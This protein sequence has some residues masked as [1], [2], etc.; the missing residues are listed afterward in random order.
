MTPHIGGLH[1]GT[2]IRSNA[3][4][5]RRDEVHEARGTAR[6]HMPDNAF[7]GPGPASVIPGS[8][9]RPC[10]PSTDLN[11]AQRAPGPEWPTVGWQLARRPTPYFVIAPAEIRARFSAFDLA[12]SGAQ[13][14]YALKANSEHRRCR[15]FTRIPVL[16]IKEA[17]DGSTVLK[18]R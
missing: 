4:P 16:T 10:R 7:I 9:E 2:K 14:Y 17:P 18:M 13:I 15:K 6:K 8:D 3:A 1:S 5:P 11:A 12:F